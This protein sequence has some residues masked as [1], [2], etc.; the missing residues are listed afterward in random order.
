MVLGFVSVECKTNILY[1]KENFTGNL[2]L[3]FGRY[4]GKIK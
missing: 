1:V 2:L 4:Y 3:G